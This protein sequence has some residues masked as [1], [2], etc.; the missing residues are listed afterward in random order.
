MPAENQSQDP[1]KGIPRS[2]LLFLALTLLAVFGAQNYSQSPSADISYSFQVEHIANLDLLRPGDS[3]KVSA[4][5][6][7]V[8][9]SGRLKKSLE[10][11]SEKRFQ[12]LDLLHQHFDL[13]TAQADL[14][15]QSQLT[16]REVLNA[17]SYFFNI[18]GSELPPKGFVV[19]GSNVD[20][21]D[22]FPPIILEQVVERS[23]IPISS[24]LDRAEQLQKL[25]TVEVGDASAFKTTTRD[26]LVQ[27]QSPVLGICGAA[28]ERLKQLQRETEALDVSNLSVFGARALNLSRQ[29]EA[30][31]QDLSS[32]RGTGRLA[33]TRSVRD[34]EQQWTQ[35]GELQQ[36]VVANSA[37]LSK[38]RQSVR[39]VTWFFHDKEVST[40][41]LE[42]QNGES[43]SQWFADARGVYDTFNDSRGAYFKAFA[44]PRNA[45]LDRMFKS[46]EPTTNYT[47]LIITAFPVLAVL[48]LLYMAFSK[49]MKGMGANALT[50]GKS[51]AKLLQRGKNRVTFRDVAGIE[52]AK[53][54]LQEVVDF[55]KDPQRF[56][57]LGA[58]IPKGIL[59]VGPPG[60]GKTLVAKA[61][62]GEADRPFFSISGSDFVEMFVGVG[63]SRIRDMFEQA[64][65]NAPCIIFMDEI[66]AVGRHRGAGMGGGHDER[67]Q[68][69]NQ[70]LVEMDGFDAN[71]GII[72]MAATNRPD[73]L[74]K[75]LLRP[76]RFDRQVMIDLPDIKGRFEILKLHARKIKLDEKV[77]LMKVAR[78]TAG[79]SGADLKNIL[80]EAALMAV[81][82][83]QEAV[84]QGDVSE[85]C[86]KV[87]FGKERR[88]L[89]ITEQEKRST[90]FHEAGHA[91]VGLVLKRCDP[92]EKVT[93]IPR[94]MS[95]GAT[96][97]LPI[98]NRLGYW[99]EELYELLAML[100]GG[101]CA[102][103]VFV[104]DVSSGAKNDIE[105]ATDI[106]RSMVCE[107]GMNDRIGLVSFDDRGDST[108]YM[109]G[110]PSS[111][112]RQLSS[113][114]TQAIDEEV[115]KLCSNA[116]A[117]ARKIIEERRDTVVFMADMLVEFETLDAKDLQLIIDSKF[118][119]EVKRRDILETSTA[120][121]PK[122][123]QTA[124]END[125]KKSIDLN[126]QQTKHS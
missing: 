33:S 122:A 45:V 1:K 4:G 36:R 47:S 24:V 92:V 32:W 101:R 60:T 35:W 14:V 40:R 85:A 2:L 121:E 97:M 15:S 87:R 72:L 111:T 17:A 115:Q 76:G 59:C 118:E 82:K 30:F 99:R 64:R 88:S 20:A 56:T 95:L 37:Q 125:G 42:K 8:T 6:D 18:S 43:Y 22:N 116:H 49:Q 65:K 53:E 124:T 31:L 27:F 13:I 48:F 106:A 12:Y 109:G 54:E 86:D 16:R 62:A 71:E 5:Q 19:K 100:M 23:S 119:V 69:L 90:A 77:E 112:S 73:V 11:G 93:V 84:A 55:L 107:W 105:R 110:Y 104:G 103:E 28:R 26:F 114:A 117:Q 67:E 75:A 39:D 70:L 98:K 34:Y 58:Q 57:S 7:L 63:A 9:F 78:A 41:S 52:E 126:L 44:Q 102:E 29:L 79:C 120:A 81:K 68:T 83:G 61:V 96:H 91:I 46:E 94:G 108:S 51:P 113:Q 21:P 10:P 80:N 123:K 74:D 25:E 66:D 50:F 3:H 89:E 38:A